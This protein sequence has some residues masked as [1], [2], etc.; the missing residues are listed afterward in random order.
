V[1]EAPTATELKIQAKEKET[2]KVSGAI[3]AKIDGQVKNIDALLNEPG[4]NEITGNW[5]GSV[6][7]SLMGLTS[8]KA[9]NALA[10]YKTIVANATLTELQELKATSPT[11]GALGAVSDAENEMLRNAAATLDRAQDLETFKAAL[12]DYKTKL[13]NAKARLLRAYEE[14]FGHGYDQ[15]REGAAPSSN[16]PSL[17]TFRKR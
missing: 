1:R 6:P 2:R 4:L 15:Y 8:Q 9:A 10:K 12:I 14:D 13:Q 5:R 3:G 16:R 11:G 17:D 7:G